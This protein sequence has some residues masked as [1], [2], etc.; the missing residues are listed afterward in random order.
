MD[1]VA[2]LVQVRNNELHVCKR[3]K[4]QQH[5]ILTDVS[6]EHGLNLLL[7]KLSFDDQLVVTVHTTTVRRMVAMEKTIYNM[8]TLTT[9]IIINIKLQAIQLVRSQ[10]IN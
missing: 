10:E 8:C 4:K 3:K 1:S 5:M 2:T 7:L 6:P 9:T